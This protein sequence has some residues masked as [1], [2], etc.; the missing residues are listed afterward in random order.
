MCKGLKISEV[1]DEKSELMHLLKKLRNG[2]ISNKSKATMERIRDS[3]AELEEMIQNP[4][5]CYCGSCKRESGYASENTNHNDDDDDDYEKDAALE[6]VKKEF[7]IQTNNFFDMN[8]KV[9][10]GV[11]LLAGTVLLIIGIRAW[12][13]AAK[14]TPTT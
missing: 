4:E 6:A 3:I 1:R 13:K 7:N 12:R 9:V 10:A 8:K 2:P 5:S 14:A 11:M